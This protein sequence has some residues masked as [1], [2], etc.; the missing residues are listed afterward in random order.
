[1]A[2]FSVVYLAVFWTCEYFPTQDG[3][4]HVYNTWVLL[5]LE[6]GSFYGRFYQAEWSLVPNWLGGAFLYATAFVVGPLMAQK[7]LLTVIF[8]VFVVGFAC[9]MKGRAEALPPSALLG[10]LFITGFA[11]HMGFFSYCLGLAMVPWVWML[12]YR[13]RDKTSGKAPWV[14]GGL[15]VLGYLAHVI[16]LCAMLMGLFVMMLTPGGRASK[17]C[18]AVMLAASLPALC[19]LGWY[20]ASFAGTN[21]QR[22]PFT[23]LVDK[24]FSLTALDGLFTIGIVVAIPITIVVLLRLL[25]AGKKDDLMPWLVLAFVAL[26]A[27]LILPNGSTGHWFLSDRLSV[28][29]WLALMPL[30]S[31]KAARGQIGAGVLFLAVVS[32]IYASTAGTLDDRVGDYVALGEKMDSE[33]VLLPLDFDPDKNSSSVSFRPFQHAAGFI[34]LNRNIVDI[35]NYEAQT[36]HFQVRLKEH[37]VGRLKERLSHNYNQIM[38][39]PSKVELTRYAPIVRYLLVRHGSNASKAFLLQ[40]N[41][42]YKKIADGG[43]ADLYLRRPLKARDVL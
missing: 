9:L 22:L 26:C 38:G 37:L 5:N 18:R 42:L 43:E 1:L 13:A 34:G 7:L 27:Y 10:P 40:L 35:S 20:L 29:P 21:T 41:R 32:T 24:L 23:N 31:A 3:P 8:V 17:R 11:L 30:M 28:L 19:M 39:D 14:I 33:S 15:L 36:D 16:A 12:A 4:S 6:P 2:V 25:S